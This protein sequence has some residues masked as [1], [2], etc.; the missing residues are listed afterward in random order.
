MRRC[1]TDPKSTSPSWPTTVRNPGV[2]TASYSRESKV[3]S[4]KDQVLRTLLMSFANFLPQPLAQLSRNDQL[5]QTD[6]ESTDEA[7]VR[8]DAHNRR[9]DSRNDRYPVEYEARNEL[10][11]GQR[12]QEEQEEAAIVRR[13]EKLREQ[14][15]YAKNLSSGGATLHSQ[16]SSPRHV[17]AD[18]GIG[19]YDN[20][21]PQRTHDTPREQQHQQ[22]PFNSQREHPSI[23][24]NPRKNLPQDQHYASTS[25]KA[26]RPADKPA[27]EP[28]HQIYTDGLN[29]YFE[30]AEQKSHVADVKKAARPAPGIFLGHSKLGAPKVPPNAMGT[31]P[32]APM[33]HT[34]KQSGGERRGRPM[35]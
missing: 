24:H 31:A 5:G 4:I 29:E 25:Q 8:D 9:N 18:E 10:S 3:P 19:Y 33:M 34:G 1:R 12:S 16:E 32:V 23:P 15:A 6:E 20:E 27:C 21:Q 26:N 11:T 17:A 28:D 35:P 2:Y 14:M 30:D 7:V 22:R 13:V